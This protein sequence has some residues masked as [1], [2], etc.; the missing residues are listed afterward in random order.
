ME[1]PEITFLAIRKNLCK[2]DH[3]N[4]N[5]YKLYLLAIMSPTWPPCLEGARAVQQVLELYPL[6]NIRSGIVWISMLPADSEEGARESAR[7]VSDSRAIHF[8]DNK[9]QVG[10]VVAESIGGKGQ[11]AWDII[12]SISMAVSGVRRLR[13]Q[14]NGC[15]SWTMLCGQLDLVFV[16]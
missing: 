2:I 4:T 11:V 13:S 7:I 10:K 12:Y 5:G 8:Y 3:F 16:V 15:T 14:K 9:K 6:A 1:T